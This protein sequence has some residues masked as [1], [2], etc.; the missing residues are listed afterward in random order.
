MM[1]RAGVGTGRRIN[2]G[3]ITGATA[4]IRSAEDGVGRPSALNEFEV[5]LS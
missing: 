4:A 2:A 3:D 5:T 1:E